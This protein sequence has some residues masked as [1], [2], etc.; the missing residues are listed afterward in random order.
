[1]K[2]R[3]RYVGKCIY[4]FSTDDLTDEHVI[5]YGLGGNLVLQ[6]ASCRRCAAITSNFE[7]KVL[8]GTLGAVRAVMGVRTRRKKKRATELPLTVERS[9]TK[10][11]E[12]IPV[13][14][15]V[16]VLPVLERGLP[17]VLFNWKHAQGLPPDY[18]GMSARVV[19][20]KEDEHLELAR[21]L[22]ADQLHVNFNFHAKE[23]GLML[24]KMAYGAAV[25][26][27]G[28]EHFEEVLVLPAILGERDDIWHW[29]GSDGG[30]SPGIVKKPRP[31]SYLWSKLWVYEGH[32]CVRF[33]LFADANTP[34]YIIVVGRLTLAMRDFFKGIGM[35]TA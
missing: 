11:V 30:V 16:P 10:V 18:V 23:L 34:E 32:T 19:L 6:K 22:K 2:A 24:A 14:E 4:C 3:S 21:K 20:R 27:H 1:M 12:Q 13:D 26:V 7:R 5:P 15:Y 31:G 35:Q 29:V 28:V 17:G 25:Y 8:R 33:K 9:G